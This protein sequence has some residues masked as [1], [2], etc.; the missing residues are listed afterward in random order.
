MEAKTQRH[1]AAAS[2]LGIINEER[3]G[4]EIVARGLVKSMSRQAKVTRSLLKLSDDELERL[5]PTAIYPD[6]VPQ[7][8]SQQLL[9]VVLRHGNEASFF[10]T[11]STR[12]RKGGEGL[13]VVLYLATTEP[14]RFFSQIDSHVIFNFCNTIIRGQKALSAEWYCAVK[15]LCMLFKY[16]D[17]KEWRYQAALPSL[18]SI[19]LGSFIIIVTKE[20]VTGARNSSQY[21]FVFRGLPMLPLITGCCEEIG[22]NLELEAQASPGPLKSFLELLIRFVCQSE[23]GLRELNAEVGL[24]VCALTSFFKVPLVMELFVESELSAF[25]SFLVDMILHPCIVG[26]GTDIFE[27]VRKT[28]LHYLTGSKTLLTWINRPI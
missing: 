21:H 1:S 26:R 23:F 15:L 9:A 5:G 16:G 10:R 2:L 24:G 13:A 17:R 4:R 25:A 6:A 19:I 11:I 27:Q 12:L 7:T 14:W 18:L 28:P 8:E 20:R 3:D 22:S